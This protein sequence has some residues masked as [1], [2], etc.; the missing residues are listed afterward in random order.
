[1]Y[2]AS[3]VLKYLHIVFKSK[4]K[5][6]EFWLDLGYYFSTTHL[7]LDLI[8]KTSN[9]KIGLISDVDRYLF[10]ERSMRGGYVI[11]GDRIM[12]TYPTGK[13]AAE[14]SNVAVLDMNSVYPLEMTHFSLPCGDYK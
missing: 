7:V 8:L 14:K 2:M 11:Q 4:N 10:A 12:E 6:K 3:D 1:M 9:E 13:R 5:I